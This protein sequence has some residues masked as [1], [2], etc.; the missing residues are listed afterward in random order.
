[1]CSESCLAYF[2]AYKGKH[3]FG[4]VCLVQWYLPAAAADAGVELFEG[5]W[6]GSRG[7]HRLGCFVSADNES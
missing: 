2:G 6:K 3:Q 5:E 7:C 4:C 1:M